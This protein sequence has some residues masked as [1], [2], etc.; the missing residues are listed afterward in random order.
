MILE[1]GRKLSN[2][3]W[4][5]MPHEIVSCLSLEMCRVDTRLSWILSWP[6]EAFQSPSFCEADFTYC[7]DHQ[8]HLCHLYL[9]LPW[10]MV[11][12]ISSFGIEK[13]WKMAGGHIVVIQRTPTND[14][15]IFH[16]QR[17]SLSLI[18]MW[19]NYVDTVGFLTLNLTLWQTQTPR[20]GWSGP[21]ALSK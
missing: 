6:F 15:T 18:K 21:T 20:R 10:T 19:M 2:N 17:S 14:I 5:R 12:D 7:L 8:Y 1:C 9:L 16:T 3:Q 13:L 4:C 11:V